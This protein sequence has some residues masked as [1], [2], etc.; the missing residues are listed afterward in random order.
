MDNFVELLAE[1]D[2]VAR[3]AAIACVDF[4][5]RLASGEFKCPDDRI[6]E[7]ACCIEMILQ[8]LAEDRRSAEAAE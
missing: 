7:V 5:R 1:D 8:A 2:R 3:Y 4:G 6:D